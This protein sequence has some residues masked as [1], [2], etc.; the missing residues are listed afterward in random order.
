MNHKDHITLLQEA[1]IQPG[2]VWA[3]L[4]SGEGAFTLALRDLVGPEGVIYSVDKNIGSLH[5][6][7]SAFE[8]QFPVSTITY[9]DKDFTHELQ[10]PQ[11][12]GLIMANSL[13]YI[14]NKIP[15]LQNILSFLKPHG[16]FILVEYNVDSGNIWVPHPISFESFVKLA[17][18]LPLSEPQLLHT[19]PSGFLKEI[20]SAIALKNPLQ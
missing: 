5:L 3:D 13:H 10:L 7:Q 11:L 19:I 17:K 2:S 20:Y 4:G 18:E 1:Q 16:K 12:D 14:K 9:L 8:E 6:Q 15:L